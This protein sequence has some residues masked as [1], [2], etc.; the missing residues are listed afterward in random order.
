VVF[1]GE[2]DTWQVEEN[3]AVRR[4]DFF[5]ARSFYFPLREYEQNLQLLRGDR[6][7]FERLVDAVVP[8]HQLPELFAQFARGERIKPQV[9]FAA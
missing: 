7:R 3:R 4:K 9:A 1:L 6:D 8:L 5:I 2:S